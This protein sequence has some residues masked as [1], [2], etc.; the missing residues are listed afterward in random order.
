MTSRRWNAEQYS[1][2]LNAQEQEWDLKVVVKLAAI[3]GIYYLML[4]AENWN[5]RKRK[6][7]LWSKGQCQA[8]SQG[9]EIQGKK[10]WILKREC[11][12][13]LDCQ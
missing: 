10:S 2:Q 3:H 12:L 6:R 1:T 8:G 11:W 4:L 7:Y 9:A 5:Q 13:C